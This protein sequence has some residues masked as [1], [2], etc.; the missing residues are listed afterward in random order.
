M[1]KNFELLQQVGTSGTATRATVADAPLPLRAE[2]VRARETGLQLDDVAREEMLRL[3][4]SVF[5]TATEAT[6]PRVVMF[7]GIDSGNGCSHVCAHAA[8]VLAD[9]VTGAVCLVDANLRAPALP[10][11]FG[12]TNHHGLTDA[13]H[14]REAIREFTKKLHPENLWLLSCG[15]VA[16]DSPA[17]I[18][19]ETM[20]LRIAELRQEFDYVL[21]DTPPLNSYSD[22]VALGR[23]V[24][25]AVLV[26]EAAATRREAILKVTA[27]LRAVN[28]KVLG[29]VLNKR[30]F[31]IPE[32]LY[33]R[34]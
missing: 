16:T 20:K 12:V 6:P 4:Q 23:L 29:A 13:L 2:H 21:I 8:A 10:E 34:L 1:S 27:D 33:R 25:G 18:N 9:N 14:S 32:A 26:L 30:A 5:L 31:A 3:V 7:S 24:D 15:S 28:T 22:G 11:F 17:L 19:S